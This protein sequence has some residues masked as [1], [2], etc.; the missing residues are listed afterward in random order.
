[1]AKKE[2]VAPMEQKEMTLEEAKAFRAS[3]YKPTPRKLSDPEKR[4][5]FRLFWVQNRK[6]Y[7]KAKSLEGIIWLH[8]KTMKMDEPEKF[9]DGL[10]HFGL[11]KIK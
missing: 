8:L 7:G 10:K 5:S 1:M 11:K 4:E 3:M 9:E 2:K 6:K